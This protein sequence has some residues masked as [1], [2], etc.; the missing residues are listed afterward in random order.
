V[1][2]GLAIPVLPCS[3]IALSEVTE[4]PQSNAKH[5]IKVTM[6]AIIDFISIVIPY[7]ILIIIMLYR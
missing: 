5:K 1:E 7:N 4:H 6:L 2:A 3:L